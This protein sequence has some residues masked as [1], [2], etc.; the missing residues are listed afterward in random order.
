MSKV[1]LHIE[2]AVATVTL[3]RPEIHNAMD[4]ETVAMLMEAFLYVEKSEDVRVLVIK[5]EGQSFCAGA[6][7]EWVKRSA[8]LTYEENVVDA[9]HLANMLFTLYKLSKP[10]IALVKG[11]VFGEGLGLAAACDIVIAEKGTSFS[12][13]EVKLGLITSV[14]SPYLVRVMGARQMMRYAQTGEVFTAEKAAFT[15]LVHE[16]VNGEEGLIAELQ[17]ITEHLFAGAP[18]AVRLSKELVHAI[19]DAV[20]DEDTVNYT[21]EWTATRR[22]S[23]EAKEGVAAFLEKRKPYWQS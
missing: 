20:I 11:S 8:N 22:E 6:D 23:D 5:G 2:N 19:A 14:I 10:T 1:L 7:L 17:A 16:I 4:E 21:A 13:P 3:N 15:G 9:E 18:N 12:I